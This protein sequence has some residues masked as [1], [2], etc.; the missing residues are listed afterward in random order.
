V[1]VHIVRGNLLDWAEQGD[2]SRSLATSHHV[3]Q[4]PVYLDQTLPPV[5]DQ[6]NVHPENQPEALIRM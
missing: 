4:L 5:Q 2:L 3:V 1:S 6:W